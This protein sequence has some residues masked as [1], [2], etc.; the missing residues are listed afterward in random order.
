MEPDFVV[1]IDLGTT[2]CAVAASPVDRPAVS[3]F[4]IEQLVAPGEVAA[5]KLLPSFLYLAG[6]EELAPNHTEL[7]WGQETPI[8]GEL[9]Q[10]LGAK[11][12][13][14]LIA[15]AKSWLVHGGLNRKA[16]IL[17]WSAPDNAPHLSPYEAS[18]LL[19]A[20]LRAA[21]DHAH[22]QSPLKE[23]DV[24]VTVPATFDGIARELTV[25][26]AEQAVGASHDPSKI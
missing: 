20:H 15:S 1:G 13:G 19:L 4:Q 2:H 7:P 16:P 12:P 10:R 21:W 23:Q 14:R 3:L 22:P 5:Q 17:P 18:S 25:Q 6:P 26:A 24:V 9:A 11:V 8:V